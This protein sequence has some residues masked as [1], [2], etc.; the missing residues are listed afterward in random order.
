VGYGS[1]CRVSVL[2][3][4]R[5]AGGTLANWAKCT[6]IEARCALWTAD[7]VVEPDGASLFHRQ[8][9]PFGR[10]N[11]RRVLQVA[12]AAVV[13]SYSQRRYQYIDDGKLCDPACH[14]FR[15]Q[16]CFACHGMQNDVSVGHQWRNG[17][18]WSGRS[19]QARLFRKA[20]C[21]HRFYRAARMGNR[22]ERDLSVRQRRANRH[23]T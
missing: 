17:R 14:R 9:K 4:G 21:R 16:S 12:D 1:P 8:L 3:H 19:L 11:V 6:V 20:Y 10:Q 7:N 5:T 18:N 13:G 23:D 22:E 15:S 2:A